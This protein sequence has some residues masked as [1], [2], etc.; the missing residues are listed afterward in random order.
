HRAAPDRVHP[1][2][3]HVHV[4]SVPRHDFGL[5]HLEAY[6]P[7]LRPLELLPLER[8]EPGE[9]RAL[10]ELHYP[11]EAGLVGRDGVVDIVA[12]QRIAR[13][14]SKRVARPE[15]A[16]LPPPRTDEREPERLEVGRAAVQLEP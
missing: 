7:P 1:R 14:G 13:L 8:G 2:A 11:A 15:A 3:V 4:V 9:V 12:I 5:G 6:E 10:L 16:R